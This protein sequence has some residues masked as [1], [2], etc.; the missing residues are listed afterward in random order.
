MAVNEHPWE[1]L[2]RDEGSDALSL[3]LAD[4]QPAQNLPHSPEQA[5]KTA[6]CPTLQAGR[7]SMNFNL[8]LPQHKC[9]EGEDVCG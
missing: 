7:L 5:G 3:N 8:L 6:G 9:G 4:T 2:W 1:V